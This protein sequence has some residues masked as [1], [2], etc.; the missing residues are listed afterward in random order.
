MGEAGISIVQN[1]FAAF[2]QT[3]FKCDF[4]EFQFCEVSLHSLSEMWVSIYIIFNIFDKN[5]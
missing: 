5:K 2:T 3:V 4:Q 1:N